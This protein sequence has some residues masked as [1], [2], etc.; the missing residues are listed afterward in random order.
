MH[1][2]TATGERLRRNHSFN[3]R[4]LIRRRREKNTERIKPPSRIQATVKRNKKCEL[5]NVLQTIYWMMKK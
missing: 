1:V 3:S 2:R 5:H 4:L